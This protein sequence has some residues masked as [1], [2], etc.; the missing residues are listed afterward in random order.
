LRSE[1]LALGDAVSDIEAAGKA[2]IA[3]LAVESGRTDTRWLKEAG[4]L[5][6]YPGCSAIVESFETTAFATATQAKETGDKPP[7]VD[8]DNAPGSQGRLV[9]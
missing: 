6:V 1:A 4:A 3:C 5:A 2:G 8:K 9:S 7:R